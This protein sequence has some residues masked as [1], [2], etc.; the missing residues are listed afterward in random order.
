MFSLKDIYNY[1]NDNP[2]VDYFVQIEKV[3]NVPPTTD[4]KLDF[5]AIDVLKKHV[6]KQYYITVKNV[7]TNVT[8]TKDNCTETIPILVETY[9]NNFIICVPQKFKLSVRKNKELSSKESWAVTM[10]HFYAYCCKDTVNLNKRVYFFNATEMG[11]C[12]L[13]NSEYTDKIKC[14][15]NWC[16][17]IKNLKSEGGSWDLKNPHRDEL[18]PNM[19]VKDENK[20]IY[21]RKYEI[22]ESIGEITLINECSFKRRKK[23]FENNV[24]SYLDPKFSPQIMGITTEKDSAKISTI[25]NANVNKLCMNFKRFIVPV[26]CKELY[27]DIETVAENKVFLIGVGFKDLNYQFRYIHFKAK[28]LSEDDILQVLRD[29]KAFLNEFRPNRTYIW[30]NFE[31]T[32]F[33]K[34]GKKYNIDLNNSIHF[35][36]CKW[37]RDNKVAFPNSNSYSLKGFGNA[38]YKEGFISSTW[39]E[40][41]TIANGRQALSEAQRRYDNNQPIDD[42]VEYNFY[43]VKV[44]Y[45]IIEYFKSIR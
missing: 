22:A 8:F 30:S 32:T 34:V 14:A 10:A 45:D 24:H 19:K 17:D 39:S 7:H 3:E 38:M 5:D 1:C 21:K 35:D 15:L 29:Y 18:Y 13:G 2:I 28:T 23:A 33:T 36:F 11:Y 27:L 41:S 37:L 12:K 40:N 20:T 43:D 42:I 25:V 31:T 9:D 26:D 6:S 16:K 44:M 4:S